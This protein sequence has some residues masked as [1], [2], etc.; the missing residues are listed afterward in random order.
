MSHDLPL[1]KHTPSPEEYAPSVLVGIPREDARRSIGLVSELPFDGV[2]VWNAHELSWLDER[3]KPEVARAEIRV[4]ATSPA[5]VES[6]SLKLYL[7]SI[8]EMRY[9]SAQ[10]VIQIVTKD[11]GE[12]VGFLLSDEAAYVNG[13][14]FQVDGG[15]T[16]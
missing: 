5:M 2:D 13:Q 16:L 14:V 6:K 7:A 4:P 1:G 3:G 12:V 9:A 10:D 15:I 8:S 11:V